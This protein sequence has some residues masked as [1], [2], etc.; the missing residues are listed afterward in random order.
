MGAVTLGLLG[1]HLGMAQ[2]AS[3]PET[4]AGTSLTRGITAA[5][6]P[7]D[8]PSPGS[9]LTEDDPETAPAAEDIA[10]G[11]Q[12]TVEEPVPGPATAEDGESLGLTA[13]H[14]IEC[15]RQRE[16]A[17]LQPDAQ[18]AACT[19]ALEPAVELDAAERTALSQLDAPVDTAASE[20]A[21]LAAAAAAEPFESQAVPDGA[22]E[23]TVAADSPSDESAAAAARR[24]PWREPKWCID[25]GVDSTWYVERMRGCG[26]FRSDLTVVDVRTGRVVGGIK[27]L[28]VGYSFTA[29]ND[30][31]WA[32]QVRLMETKRWGS[33][34][35]GTRAYGSAACT[36]KCKVA[37]K[38][39]P[40]QAITAS[41]EPYGQFF[42]DTTINT[43][44]R[45][46]RGTGRSIAVWRFTNPAW[47]G[48]SN[49]TKL[50][51]V[52]VRCDT[53]MPGTTRQVGCVNLR[54]V[55]VLSYSLNGPWPELADHIRDAQ[56][57]GLPGKYGTT[58]YLTRLTDREK[59]EE[60]RE[61]ACPRSL[62][63][64]PGKS[65]DEYPFA[66]TWQGAKYS[67]GP[68]SRRM[69]NDTQNTE[70]GRALKG[71]YVYSRVLEGDRFLVW[72]R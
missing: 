53:A 48:P 42:M 63:R 61:E 30:K 47:P 32:Y 6:T 25:A 68:F 54:A 40:S 10:L 26:I 69:I 50:S 65:C 18:Y 57:T 35:S 55:P 72:I 70:G 28:I 59:N 38:D 14:Q 58:H 22:A 56:A 5:D 21:I 33:G 16:A 62:Q 7:A 37:K 19:S 64:P 12:S 49:A 23:E 17:A 13:G 3:G 15:D 60:N 71:F 4:A 1:S 27:Y 44:V 43:A 31:R 52:E 36:G 34:V 24:S 2:A 67:G 41:A 66:S 39:F 11:A 51:S 9:E 8:E 29:R 46:Q 45:M 20:S